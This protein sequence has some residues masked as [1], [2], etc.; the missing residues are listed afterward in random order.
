MRMTELDQLMDGYKREGID[1]TPYYWYTD[2]VRTYKLGH[3]TFYP[4]VFSALSCEL[5]CT[6]TTPGISRLSFV[7]ISCSHFCLSKRWSRPALCFVGELRSEESLS[8]YR[9][10][11]NEPENV[12]STTRIRDEKIKG[13]DLRSIVRFKRWCASVRLSSY[14]CTYRWQRGVGSKFVKQML[15]RSPSILF[16]TAVHRQC[17]PGLSVNNYRELRSRVDRLLWITPLCGIHVYIFENVLL[18]SS[19]CQ[20]L[21]CQV[22]K[23]LD[24]FIEWY[25]REC[26]GHS[27]CLT[28]FK[29][30]A[31]WAI[32]HGFPVGYVTQI[33]LLPCKLDPLVKGSE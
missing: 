13:F 18:L 20:Y 12:C 11:C 31:N 33:V 29:G 7:R 19:H 32:S 27:R 15:N 5:V 10:C 16:A 9:Y 25:E 6:T 21:S 1:P 3:L 4:W 24:Y 26:I 14:L 17:Q 23:L 8:T 28:P 22:T 2:Q 30:R